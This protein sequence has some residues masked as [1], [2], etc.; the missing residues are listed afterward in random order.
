MGLGWGKEMAKRVKTGDVVAIPLDDGRFAFARVL[1]DAA[2]G[3]YEYTAN[4][5]DV[6]P[7][8]DTPYAFVVGVYRDVLTSGQWPVV[9]RQPFPNEEDA[10]PPPNVV[11][12]V[13]SGKVSIYYK[14]VMRPASSEEAEGLE[15]AAV[16][17]KEHILERIGHLG[18]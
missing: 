14:G 16:W 10:W 15:P 18:L 12:D 4:S 3:V 1:K 17:D 8:I 11:R 9:L 6:P 7:P 5:Q 2:I 13:I